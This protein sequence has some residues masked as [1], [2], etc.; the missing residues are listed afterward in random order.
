[1]LFESKSNYTQFMKLF[2]QKIKLYLRRLW[3]NKKLSQPFLEKSERKKQKTD[4]ICANFKNRK[5]S[6]FCV[7]SNRLHFSI[8]TN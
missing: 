5:I 2:N 3:K 1:M 6:R 8:K 4:K 7:F